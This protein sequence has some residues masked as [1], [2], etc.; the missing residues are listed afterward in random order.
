MCISLPAWLWVAIVAPVVL[1]AA[2]VGE[3]AYVEQQSLRPPR[4]PL[5]PLHPALAGL[6]LREVSFEAPDGVRLSAWHVPS[7]NGAAVAMFHGY[8]GNRQQLTSEAATLATHGYGVLLVDSRAH[9]QSGG[10]ETTHGDRERGDVRAA[11]D[12]LASGADAPA[13]L[14]LLGFSAGAAP[15]PAVAAEDPRVGAVVLAGCTTSAT[16]FS[17]DESG[18]LAWL[19]SPVI[20]AV[21]R[22][23]GI[24]PQA[25]DPLE[26]V[27]R[28]SPR[29]VLIVHGE[30]DSIVPVA[31]ARALF[32]AAGEPKQ[33]HV[34]PGAGHGGYGEVEPA[35]YPQLLKDFFDRHLLDPDAAARTRHRGADDLTGRPSPEQPGQEPSTHESSARSTHSAHDSSAREQMGPAGEGTLGTPQPGRIE[36]GAR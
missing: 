4:T 9:G 19:K 14:G 17:R 10:A 36:G 15:L 6:P 11:L 2:V 28:L 3:T 7:R 29:A 33:L 24:D 8:A 31:R 35:V 13:R 22:A 34:V 23:N 1:L 30:S 32:A 25:I 12:F 16:Q 18:R 26:A 27:S 5:E 21:M 20:L